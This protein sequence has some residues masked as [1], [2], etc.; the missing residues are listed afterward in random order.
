[1]GD[2]TTR[3]Y[4]GNGTLDQYHLGNGYRAYNPALQRFT[5]PDSLSPFGMKAEQ[6]LT[7][8]PRPGAR[9]GGGAEESLMDTAPQTRGKTGSLS[10]SSRKKYKETYR[11]GQI[12]EGCTPSLSTII[13]FDF[14]EKSIAVAVVLKTFV[15]DTQYVHFES[16]LFV[17]FSY[18]AMRI[19]TGTRTWWAVTTCS[20]A[21][22][23]VSCSSDRWDCF[24]D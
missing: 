3:Y 20:W 8:N 17:I 24:A 15:F 11:L 12:S 5:C 4:Y 21:T 6:E 7:V 18:L 2:T 1:M 9:I 19:R 23:P 10:K 14:T 16:V 13:L 22:Q